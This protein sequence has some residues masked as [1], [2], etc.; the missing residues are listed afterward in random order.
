MVT[1]TSTP[2]IIT[3]SEHIISRAHIS[4]NALRVLY[5]LRDAG[6]MAF[7]VG[8][9]VRDLL[10]GIEPKDFDVAT[11]ALPE[12][13][14][15]LFRNCRLVGR[16]FRLAHVFFGRDII[17]VA[18]FR[19]ASAP[20][21]GEEPLP[22]AD[23]A[24]GED[25]DLEQEGGLDAAG[26]DIASLEEGSD[27]EDDDDDEDDEDDDEPGDDAGHPPPPPVPRRS[28]RY[29]ER[30]AP[31]N[32]DESAADLDVDPNA[33]RMFD[34]TG[35]IL[36]DNVYGTI[37]A[38]VWRRD[39]T[40][41]ALYYNI[42]DFSIWDYVG[43]FEDIAARKLKLIGDPETRFREDPVRMLRAARFEAKLGFEIDPAT[44]E[45][46]ERLK[47][48]LG[49]VPPARLFDETLKLFLTGHG[50]RSFEVLRQRGLLAALLPSVD[51][52]FRK[53][54]GS[55]VEQLVMR[56]LENTDARV[57]ADKPVTPTFLF[58][59]LLY[60][61]IAAIIESTPPERWHELGT[62]LDACD[63]A[64]RQVQSHISLPKRFSL[65]MREMFA[66]QPRLEH[67]RGRRALRVLEHPRFRAAYDLLLLRAEYGLASAEIAQWWTRIQE[68]SADE[69]GQMA[70]ALT[71]QTQRSEGGA[72]RRGGRRRRRRRGPSSP[73]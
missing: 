13:V 41:N 48:L 18:T 40:A 7:L 57:L 27:L 16:R 66:L 17:E 67:P 11:D 43:G 23:V 19:A 21:P 44:A 6:F 15:K 2:R 29:R 61:P 47:G 33:E 56:G 71:G 22:E 54:P 37:D 25:R 24:E 36:R 1:P 58:A 39:L 35:R 38:D 12:Q 64:A 68:V 3:R 70:D 62:I 51:D 46:I 30:P 28:N 63:R 60:G 32:G 10:I 45:P 5:R 65:G 20:E 31:P 14:R 4:S 50:R 59:L 72:P 69:R 34:E 42:A 49:G 55:L 26:S 53:H 73:A 9:C 52:Y 8:G